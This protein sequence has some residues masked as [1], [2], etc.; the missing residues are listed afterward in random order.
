MVIPFIIGFLG[1]IIWLFAI[2]RQVR[3]NYFFFFVVCATSTVLVLDFTHPARFYLG[4]GF[5]LIISLYNFRKIPHYILVLLFIL[6][7]SII[8]PMILTIETIVPCLIIE[9]TIIFFIILKR[10]VLYSFDNKKLNMFHFVLLLFEISAITR[11]IVVLKNLRTG[12][13]FF[14]VTAAFGI[15]MG[16]FFL[17]YNENNSPKISL[18]SKSIIDTD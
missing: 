16:I 1:D 14:Y 5:F 12:I 10:T 2:F 6:I 4:Q 9:H 11:F 13:V 8:L 3:T 17:L 18:E 15:L 7:I